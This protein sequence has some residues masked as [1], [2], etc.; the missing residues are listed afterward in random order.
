MLSR[1]FVAPFPHAQRSPWYRKVFIG[2]VLVT[3]IMPLLDY[4]MQEYLT[5]KVL[6][7]YRVG[8]GLAA[9]VEDEETHERYCVEFRDG[10]AGASLENFFGLLKERFGGITEHLEKLISEGDYVA[11]TVSYSKGPLRQAYA[12]HSVS[13]SSAYR[14]AGRVMSFSR[15]HG[16]YRA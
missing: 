9:V 11:L 15:S 14:N 13:R 7:V 6:D 2:G 12:I 10:Y 4:L 8:S 16:S 5:G 3:I 1:P